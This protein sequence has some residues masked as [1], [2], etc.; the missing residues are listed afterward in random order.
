M[1]NQASVEMPLLGASASEVA[2]LA[3]NATA[4]NPA[5]Q[6][7]SPASFPAITELRRGSCSSTVRNVACVNSCDQFVANTTSMS[8]PMN[9]TTIEKA[10]L[11]PAA[12]ARLSIV[13]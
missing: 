13:G 7:R 12:V 9:E 11:P 6:T 1:V 2:Q 4:S 10:S 3:T 8:T 5:T